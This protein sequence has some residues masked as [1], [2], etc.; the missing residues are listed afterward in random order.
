MQYNILTNI[1]ISFSFK[2]KKNFIIFNFYANSNLHDLFFNEK[3]IL[4][5]KLC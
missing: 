4:N 5:N 1:F 2:T 3:L